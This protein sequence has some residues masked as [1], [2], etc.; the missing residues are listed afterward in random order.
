MRIAPEGVVEGLTLFRLLREAYAER[1]SGQLQVFNA[2]ER[3]VLNLDHGL[4]SAPAPDQSSVE[5]G[6]RL[7]SALHWSEAKYRLSPG[8]Y[9]SAAAEAISIPNLILSAV[10]CIKDERLISSQVGPRT[11]HI[12][13]AA[14]P[15]FRFQK[16]NLSPQEAYVLSRIEA[17]SSIE[18][19][20]R[21]SALTELETLRSL[22][23]FLATGLMDR[24]E[25]TRKV[26]VSAPDIRPE[27]GVAQAAPSQAN[28]ESQMLTEVTTTLKRLR[29]AGYFEV[30]GVDP[31]ASADQ[32]KQAYFTLAKKF[33]PDKYY[34]TNSPALAEEGSRLFALI[35]QAYHTLS[36]DE[37]KSRYTSTLQPTTKAK[38]VEKPQP[39]VEDSPPRTEKSPAKAHI[40]RTHGKSTVA[41]KRFQ[42]AKIAIQRSD[43]AEALEH[44]REAVRLEPKVAAYQYLLGKVLSRI[45][46]RTAEAVERFENAVRLE[47][48]NWEYRYAL[49]RMYRQQQQPERAE[50]QFREAQRLNPDAPSGAPKGEKKSI[51][52][53]LF[54]RSRSS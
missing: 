33:H 36:N 47:P 19:L 38:T 50:E 3:L 49:G 6:P 11:G 41:E 21:I 44:L 40:L 22:L 32:I 15:F 39:P 51:F 7:E 12:A 1:F 26:K 29:A 25:G 27:I 16:L 8:A 23:A 28:G 46:K 48:N 9:M 35:T 37:L 2:R 10:R 31:K 30:L 4:A 45:P 14:D 53:R 17:E 34:F 24:V 13:L 43:F 42:S 18:D 5:L 54:R 52:S 20:C